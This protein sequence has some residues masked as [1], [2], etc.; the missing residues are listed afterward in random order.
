M[1]MAR[2]TGR[3]MSK[4]SVAEAKDRLPALIAA[5]ERG[6]PVTITRYGTP[7]AELRP[8]PKARR[9]TR[10]SIEWLRQQL[11]DL[12]P[13]PEDSGSLVRRM[14]DEDGDEA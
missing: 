1:S 9:V 10:E 14:R 5:A 11:A 2:M 4:Y 12:P 6:E 3:P 13:M 8:V 7:V